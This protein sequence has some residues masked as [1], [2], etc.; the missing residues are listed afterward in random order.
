MSA[1]YAAGLLLA[2]STTALVGCSCP[3]YDVMP[4][5]FTLQ[6]KIDT[7]GTTGFRW[8]EVEAA[9]LVRYEDNN[10]QQL[11]DTLHAST[12]GSTFTEDSLQ[13]HYR[14]PDAAPLFYL[15]TAYLNRYKTQYLPLKSFALHVGPDVFRITN[16]DL[17]QSEH[18][19]R[20][21]VSQVDHYFAT[22]NGQRIDARDGYLLTR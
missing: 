16:L 5:H 8:Q 20:C 13:L 21:P 6:F 17:Q 12:S 2:L 9:Y 22:I 15:Q 1:R 18:G 10:F 11:V 3:D 4:V 19:F 7:L 14:G